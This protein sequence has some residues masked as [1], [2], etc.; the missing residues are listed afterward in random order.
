MSLRSPALADEFFTTSASGKPTWLL[1][2]A[3]GPS[4]HR[5]IPTFLCKVSPF[6]EEQTFALNWAHAGTEN[7]GSL[8]PAIVPKHMLHNEKLGNVV[9]SYIPIR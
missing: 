2:F 9:S 6:Q 1:R 7:V 5:Q 3:K 4:L 8:I